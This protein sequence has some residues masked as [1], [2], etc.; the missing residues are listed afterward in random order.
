MLQQKSI[1]V[2]NAKLKFTD[3]GIE[4]IQFHV[5]SEYGNGEKKLKDWLLG[6]NSSWKFT[7]ILCIWIEKNIWVIY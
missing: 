6:G 1:Y 4:I 5:E 3:G 2:V 7:E